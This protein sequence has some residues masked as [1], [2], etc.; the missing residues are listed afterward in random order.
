MYFINPRPTRL[1]V[2]GAEG[3]GVGNSAEPWMA[4]RSFHRVPR[5][6]GGPQQTSGDTALGTLS[7]R[8]KQESK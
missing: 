3:D 7:R 4:E 1:M 6:P 8:L 5:R 2:P